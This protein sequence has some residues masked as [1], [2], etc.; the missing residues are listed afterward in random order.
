MTQR[1]GDPGTGELDLE[2]TVP[3]APATQAF[4]NGLAHYRP[5]HSLEQI[6]LSGSGTLCATF[7]F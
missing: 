5:H 2:R 1:A 7:D 4:F 6:M 3:A